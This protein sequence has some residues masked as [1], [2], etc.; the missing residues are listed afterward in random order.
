MRMLKKV[1]EEKTLIPFAE[2]VKS[3]II[4]EKIIEF[5]NKSKELNI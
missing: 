2:G 1:I 3:V 5:F 4:A